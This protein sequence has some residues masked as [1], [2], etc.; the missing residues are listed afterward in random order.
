MQNDIL[1]ANVAKGKWMKRFLVIF[2]ALCLAYLPAHATDSPPS[3]CDYDANRNEEE[4]EPL[5]YGAK[6]STDTG[7]NI[8]M[9]GWGLGLA[10]AIAI[11]AGVIHQSTAAH[12]NSSKSSG[13]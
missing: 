7:I 11:L 1:Q 6:K 2:L 13:S 9:I 8:S 4:C 3:E 12:S 10:A 5:G